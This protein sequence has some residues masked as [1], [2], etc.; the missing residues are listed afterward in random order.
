MPADISA[1]LQD[2]TA[3][4]ELLTEVLDNS[5]EAM[6]ATATPAPGWTVRDQVTHLAY[7]DEAAVQAA[8]DP[9]AFAAHQTEVVRDVDGFTATVAR[10]YQD[11]SG[12]QSLD[13]F[14]SARARLV[15]TFGA[16][17]GSTRM[18]WYGPDMSPA[19]AVTA[20]L[21]ETWAHG[22][23]VFDALGRE[24]PAGP[25]LRQVAHLGVRTYANSFRTRGLAV[26]DHEVR[27]ELRGPHGENWEWG[28]PGAADLVQGPAVDFCLVVTQRRHLADTRLTVR[29][30]DASEW[31]SIAQ[32][33]AGPAGSGRRP[34]QFRNAE[35]AG[36]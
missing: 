35:V 12:R 1:L 3:E 4:T 34:G 21:M 15:D 17:D 8:T 20:R 5:T 7:F 9:A 6:W 32:A 24:H 25:G 27:V 33:F 16:I 2:L 28:P 14:R 11:M 23:D 31:M 36:G 10:R 18:P 19:S 29:G 30:R 13:W 22:Q 26:P